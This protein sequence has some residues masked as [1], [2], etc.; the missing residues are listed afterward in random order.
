M[1]KQSI[2]RTKQ[3]KFDALSPSTYLIRH[4]FSHF[5]QSPFITGRVGRESDQKVCPLAPYLG[6]PPTFDRIAVT[7]PRSEF[8]P[9]RTSLSL[10]PPVVVAAVTEF[11]KLFSALSL[12]QFNFAQSRTV[13]CGVG[14]W[15][16]DEEGKSFSLE[17]FYCC[18]ATSAELS[19]PTLL[20]IGNDL[21]ESPFAR[22]VVL[23]IGWAAVTHR[24][25]HHYH[26]RHVG[27]PRRCGSRWQLALGSEGAESS[28]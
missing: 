15:G 27:S 4:F 6:Q 10:Q 7:P 8:L 17:H 20:L 14:C 21:Y 12:A 16:G 3:P 22:M 13:V 11:V 24:T 26:H 19:C 1:P 28:S 25:T 9:H 18:C 5:Q 23:L 2:T